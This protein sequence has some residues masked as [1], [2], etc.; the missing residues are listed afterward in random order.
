MSRSKPRGL[1][2]TC[3]CGAFKDGFRTDQACQH[4]QIQHVKAVHRD[5]NWTVT[6]RQGRVIYRQR[7][8]R[9]VIIAKF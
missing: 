3:S 6:N 1:S 5:Q 9:K 2:W 4:S 8:P 7:A